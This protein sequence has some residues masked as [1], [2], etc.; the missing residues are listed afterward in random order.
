MC[1]FQFAQTHKGKG[2]FYFQPEHKQN[3]NLRT[4]NAIIDATPR[5]YATQTT[6]A[7]QRMTARKA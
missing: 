2:H 1:F 3:A 7:T 4:R 6:Q 5:S